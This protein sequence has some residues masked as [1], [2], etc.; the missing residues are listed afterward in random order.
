[1]DYEEKVQ[2]I[3]FGFYGADLLG[4]A[5]LRRYDV[6]C[7]CATIRA[8]VPRGFRTSISWTAR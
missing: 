3:R 8:S 4:N 1:M 5:D 7:V 2:S 6:G